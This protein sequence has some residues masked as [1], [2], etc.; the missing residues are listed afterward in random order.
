MINGL[1]VDHDS[2][3]HR[4]SPRVKLLALPLVATLLFLT[5]SLAVLLAALAAVGLLYRLARLDF[6]KA[7]A[8]LRPALFVLLVLFLAQ[9]LLED[10]MAGAVIVVRL[11]TLILLASL[12]TLTTRTA[13]MVDA[14]EGAMHPLKRLGVDPRRMSLAIS[15]AIRFIPVVATVVSECREAQRARGL[16]RSVI[17]LAVPVIIRTLKMADEIAD[18]IDARS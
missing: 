12:V 16:E 6:C 3:V 10:W 17:A 1:Y 14:L 9:G 13:A 8:Q 18:A 15:L 5:D 11:V 2:P 7:L 4:L